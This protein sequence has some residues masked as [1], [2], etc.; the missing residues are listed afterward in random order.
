LL[1]T[2][3][4]LGCLPRMAR[5][6]ACSEDSGA[7][8]RVLL[9][10]GMANRMDDCSFSFGTRT[11]R[12]TF[13]STADGEI[14]NTIPLEEYLYGVVPMEVPH[15]WPQATL[16]SQA[17]LS[18]TFALAR[19]NPARYYDVVASQGDQAYGGLDAEHPETS[20]AVS[21]TGGQVLTFDGDQATVAY[22]SCCGGHT[23]SAAEAWIGGSSAPYLRGVV[24]AYCADAPDFQ[25]QR[26]I[27]LGSARNAFSDLWSIANED[28]RSVQIMSADPSGRARTIR[29]SS[30]AGGFEVSGREFRR[31]LGAVAVRSL[32]IHS[33]Q[34]DA[35]AASLTIEGSGRGH[36][37]GLCQWGARALGA[38]GHRV[39]DILNFYFPGT[40]LRNG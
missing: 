3:A 38:A 40:A 33:I 31:R 8:I 37:V 30:S 35:A 39:P 36:G 11:Y 17:I 10:R 16:Q 15:S 6:G 18:R 12:G 24:C 26:D 7:S 5:A 34:V 22:M 20:A 2:G 19:T 4:A 27:P 9:G 32:L 28:L 25:W 13:A 23:E 21:A 29:F 14:V 1:A